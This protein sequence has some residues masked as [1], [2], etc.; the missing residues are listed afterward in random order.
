[1]KGRNTHLYFR[2]VNGISLLPWGK[3]V[4]LAL[5]AKKRKKS[6]QAHGYIKAVGKNPASGSAEDQKQ[7]SEPLKMPAGLS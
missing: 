6:S 1:M 7:L 4:N 2:L 3:A 5:E